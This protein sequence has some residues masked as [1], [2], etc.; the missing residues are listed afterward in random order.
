MF[1]LVK[2]LEK[3]HAD[4]AWSVCWTSQDC[5]L[6]SGVDE[7]VKVLNPPSSDQKD[8]AASIKYSFN[9]HDLG[10]VSVSAST[11]GSIAVSSCMDGS[12]RFIV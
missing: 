8:A 11:D 4:A 3:V 5:I 1:R 9:K 2:R 6:T 10:V 7:C 12:L